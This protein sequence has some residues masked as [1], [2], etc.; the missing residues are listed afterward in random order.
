M[1]RI[2]PIKTWNNSKTDMNYQIAKMQ[3]ALRLLK[4]LHAH[5]GRIAHPQQA[6]APEPYKPR[7]LQHTTRA[8]WCVL[9]RLTPHATCLLSSSSSETAEQVTNYNRHSFK[10]PTPLIISPYMTVLEANVERPKENRATLSKLRTP[11]SLSH[12]TKSS[13]IP[14]ILSPRICSEFSKLNISPPTILIS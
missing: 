10:L 5:G 12:T 8:Q 6:T 13:Q 11:P 2:I 3:Q 14:L 7:S 1:I 4:H 9:K